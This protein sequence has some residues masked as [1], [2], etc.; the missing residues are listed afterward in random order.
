MSYYKWSYLDK[1][2]VAEGHNSAVA[3]DDGKAYVVYH[4]RFNDGTEGHQVRVH[5]LFTAKTEVLLRRRLSIQARHYLSLHIA[6]MKWQENTKLYYTNKRWTIITL[7]VAMKKL[8][9]LIKMELL[10]VIIQVH[11][12]SQ[13]TGHT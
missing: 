5:Q 12:C 4:T 13:K 2:R 10:Q 7:N 8:S 6:M 1:G 11:G 3:D 9:S